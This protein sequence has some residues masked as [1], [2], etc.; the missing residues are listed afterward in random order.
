MNRIMSA[1]VFFTALSGLTA[2]SSDNDNNDGGTPSATGSPATGGSGT[3]DAAGG[4]G[5][6]SSGNGTQPAGSGANGPDGTG[7]GGASTGGSTNTGSSGGGGSGAGAVGGTGGGTSAG[8]SGGGGG[9][10]A[11]GGSTSVPARN[12]SNAP[13]S[14]AEIATDANGNAFAVW[15]QHDGTRNNVYYSRFTSGNWSA[16]ALL[17][18]LDGDATQPDVAMNS[19]GNAI[20]VWTQPNPGGTGSPSDNWTWARYFSPSTGWGTPALISNAGYREGDGPG[21]ERAIV[22]IDDSG[23]GLAIW[24]DKSLAASSISLAGNTYRPG[25]GWETSRILHRSWTYYADL[26]MDGRGNAVVGYVHDGGD[27]DETH[28]MTFSPTSGWS[29]PVRVDVGP[30]SDGL[31]SVGMDAAGNALMAWAHYDSLASPRGVYFSRRAPG[32]TWS[33][34]ARISY[35]IG[36]FV[37]VE[38]AVAANGNAVVVWQDRPEESVSHLYAARYENHAW[39]LPVAIGPGINPQTAMSGDGPFAT[40]ENDGTVMWTRY[41]GSGWTTPLAIESHPETSSAPR[42]AGSTY[43]Q[44]L[45]AWLQPSGV[46]ARRL[47]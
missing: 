18:N 30:G 40:Y 23:I 9:G 6:A 13:A 19:A 17:E 27:V 21:S 33:A 29:E 45:F 35:D 32:G 7:S 41:N 5:D 14:N 10:G 28:A 44:P 22:A 34:P 20:A 15:Q 26:A 39:Q 4:A 46:W 24:E 31:V 3:A 2:C 47:P 42:I 8:G 16:P 12:V 36:F 25:S 11:G 37:D 38:L 1:V 43:A